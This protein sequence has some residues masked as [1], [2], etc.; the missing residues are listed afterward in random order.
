M[1]GPAMTWPKTTIAATDVPCPTCHAPARRTCYPRA[2]Q[3]P[4][5]AGRSSHGERHQEAK[6]V[7]ALDTQAGGVRR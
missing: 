3:S 5:Y 2:G 7:R 1:T 6:K 4:S